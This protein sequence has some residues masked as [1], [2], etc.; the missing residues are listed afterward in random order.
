MIEKI[1]ILINEIQKNRIAE[2]GVE[3]FPIYEEVLTYN[4]WKEY[5]DPQFTCFK[6]A[7]GKDLKGA[8]ICSNTI[9]NQENDFCQNL[10]MKELFLME[11]GTFKVFIRKV[12]IS[13][14]PDGENRDFRE[15]ADQDMSCFNYCEII[16]NIIKELE[17]RLTRF[18]R[19]NKAQTTRL[20]RL[21]QLKI[22]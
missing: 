4:N 6:N 13:N 11:D 22:S 9:K 21:Q 19:L 16:E 5:K 12:T 15:V 14:I 17:K 10:Q 8:V 20:E 1:E 3:L 18:G 2:K 7:E